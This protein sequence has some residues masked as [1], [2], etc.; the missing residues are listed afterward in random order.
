MR[1][2]KRGW[3]NV[4]IFSTLFMIL[5]FNTTHQKFV[6][7][8]GVAEKQPLIAAEA[9]IQVIDYSG[10]KFERI[11]SNWRVQSALEGEL[12][13]IP[14]QLVQAWQSLTFEILAESPELSAT[15][16]SLPV[17]VQAIG[18]DSQQIFVVYLEPSSGLAYFHNKVLDVW[19]LGAIQE[20]KLLVPPVLLKEVE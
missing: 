13:I 2:T 16:Y 5:L 8:E 3:N 20:V 17:L 11:G 1:L 18:L 4:L 14:E 6:E 15:S 12:N 19:Q 10:I 9:I 7:G